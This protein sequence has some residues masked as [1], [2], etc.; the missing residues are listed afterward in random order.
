MAKDLNFVSGVLV[1]KRFHHGEQ[2]REDLGGVD[3]ENTAEQFRVVS[4]VQL[5][6]LNG[7]IQ[8]YEKKK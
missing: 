6:Q 1:H 4:F 8:G 3:N 2:Y 5:D 7:R